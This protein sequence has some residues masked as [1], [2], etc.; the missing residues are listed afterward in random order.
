MSRRYNRR[1]A[2]RLLISTAVLS[3][4]VSAVASERG[5]AAVSRQAAAPVLSAKSLRI[6]IP[7]AENNLT[8]F[9]ITFGS[10]PNTHDF[11]N[12]V[13][14]PLFWSQVKTNPDPWLAESAEPNADF[15]SWT[16]KL[17]PDLTWQDGMPLTAEDVLF[18]FDYYLTYKGSA[19]RYAHHVSDV[20]PYKSGE[21]LDPLTVRLDFSAPAPQFI[22]LPGADLP[23]VPKH[24]WEGITDPKTM[25]DLPIGSGPYQLVEIQPDQ[26]YRLKANPNYVMG[27]PTVD[28]LEIVVVK[29]PAAAFAALQTGDVDMVARNVPPELRDQFVNGGEVAMVAGSKFESTQIF[30]NARKAPLSDPILRK[31]ISMSTDLQTIVDTVLLG[32]GLPG[33][34]TF[35][36]PDSPWAAPTPGHEYDSAA[37]AKSLDDAGYTVG[38]DGVRT[39]PEGTRLEFIIL[40]NSFEPAD[41]RAAQL[42]AEQTLPLGVKFMVESLDP[43]TLRERRAS[44]V[45]AVP[46]YDAYV[47]TL[48]AHAH[49]DPDGLYY[50]FHSPGAKGFGVSVSGF[51][52]AS[53]DGVVEG[54]TIIPLNERADE[55]NAAEEI[56]GEEVPGMILWY[57]TGE[58]AFRPAAYGGWVADPGHGILTKRSFLPD[59]VNAAHPATAVPTTEPVAPASVAEGSAATAAPGAVAETTPPTAVTT[60]TSSDDS[61]DGASAVPWVIGI[62]AVVA[63]GA[64]LFMKRRRRPNNEDDD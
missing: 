36:H 40:V 12:L 33:S 8:P 31:A 13:Y 57:R 47:S 61:D 6:A 39:S 42:V 34:D 26:L 1:V 15:T 51:T 52:N 56:I 18:S 45:D 21:V 46:A 7:G 20:P 9:T 54:A 49:V 44:T 27:Q 41:I 19:G 62:A 38:A 28:E 58:Y 17:K 53:F 50:F 37:A 14:D 64:V 30:F 25:L 5:L 32:Q 29:D 4:L 55:L 23:I 60:S 16:V 43:A 48:E 24:Q 63:I 59:T 22:S 2:L 3:T 11:L 10:T 35:I